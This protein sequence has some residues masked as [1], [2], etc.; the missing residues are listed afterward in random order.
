MAGTRRRRPP[1]PGALNDLPPLKI[2]RQIV[3]LQSIYYISALLLILFTALV[4]GKRFNL[5][6]LFSW[7]SIRGDTTVGWMLGV[8]WLLNGGVGYVWISLSLSQLSALTNSESSHFRLS[9][10]S[11]SRMH[12]G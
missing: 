5:D 10:E 9:I 12:D 4:A 7:R 8:V 2:I 6:L 11:D 1:R 3:L